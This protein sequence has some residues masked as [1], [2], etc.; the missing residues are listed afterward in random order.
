MNSLSVPNVGAMPLR[1]HCINHCAGIA[2]RKPVF[3]SLIN[4]VKF[5]SLPVSAVAA[6]SGEVNGISQ[7]LFLKI[8]QISSHWLSP[9]YKPTV[10]AVH[11]FMQA[12]I[13]GKK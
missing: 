6:N 3:H 9:F 5:P 2:E 7:A 13:G 8:C 12:S 1:R 10:M 4:S 11:K